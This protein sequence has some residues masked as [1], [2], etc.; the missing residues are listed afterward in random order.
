MLLIGHKIETTSDNFGGLIRKNCLLVDK[1]LMIEKFLEGS[2]VS[3]IIR[4]RR[5]GKT[6]NLSMLQHFLAAEVAGQTTAGLFDNLA[7][8]KIDSGQFLKIHQGQYPVIFITFK[9]LKESS[10]K[11]TI[12]KAVVLIQELYQEHKQ[13]LLS[14]NLDDDDRILFKQYLEAS[15]SNAQLENSLKFLSH[16]LFKVYGK[17]VVILID[18]YDSPLTSAYQHTPKNKIGSKTSFLSRLSDFMRNL[19]SAALK[20]NAYLEKG[21]MTGILRVSKNNMLS[22]LNN[23]EVY[24]LLSDEYAQYFGF[25]EEE[26]KALLAYKQNITPIEQVRDYYNGYKIGGQVIVNPWSFMKFLDKNRLSPYWVATSNDSTIRDHLIQSDEP[27]KK[28]FRALILGETITGDIDVNLK[29]EELIEKPSALWT[30]LL[31]CGYLTLDSQREEDLLWVC[32]LKIPNQEIKAQYYGIFKAWLK[33]H[34][35]PSRYQDFLLALLQGNIPCFMRDLSEYLMSSLSFR[36]I[37]GPTS[38]RFYHGFVLGLMAS[39]RE[40]HHVQSN[41]ESGTGLPDLLLIPKDN[42]YSVGIVMEFKYTPEEVL[43][44]Q[45]VIDAMAQMAD[46]KYD[47]KLKNYPCVKRML[48]IGIAF[49]SKSVLSAHQIVDLTQKPLKA[50]DEIYWSDVYAQEIE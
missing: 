17:N 34:I 45:K 33:E 7:I 40:S 39:V 48:K 15:I 21:L 46:K 9:D 22:G 35:G 38:E 28:A 29:Y 32:G 43:L 26:I 41:S 1:S 11:A 12:Q 6:I 18:E 50:A 27:T 5:F 3:L 30:L 20:T 25:T 8:A 14:P 13:H 16:F 44:K 31:F 10:Y 36:D 37:K 23:L 24:T 19:F 47:A 2:E 42:R 49:C 4:P